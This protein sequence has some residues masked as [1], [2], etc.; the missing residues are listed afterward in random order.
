MYAKYII[1]CLSTK[2][3]HTKGIY[4]HVHTDDCTVGNQEYCHLSKRNRRRQ[5]ARQVEVPRRSYLFFPGGTS[6]GTRG[7]GWGHTDDGQ[8]V[9]L[10]VRSSNQSSR[11]RGKNAPSLV[12]GVLPSLTPR[13]RRDFAF[14]PTAVS[15]PTPP[16]Q[17][18]FLLLQP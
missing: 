1:R 3:I 17:V 8:N 12:V 13:G 16:P 15:S 4:I 18:I 5:G 7:R 9:E 6:V 14:L 11:R 10:D 2:F